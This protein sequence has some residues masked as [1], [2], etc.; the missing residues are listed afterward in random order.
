MTTTTTLPLTQTVPRFVGGGRIERW[1][2]PLPT[3]GDGELLLAVRA[4]ALCG[5]DRA[6]LSAGSAVTPGHEAAGE[7]VSAGPGTATAPGTAG[8]VYLMDYCG[9]CRSCTAGATNRCSAKRADMGFTH[10]GGLGR[11][12]LV[13]E[14]NFFPVGADLSAHEATLL[15]DVMGTTAHALQRARAIQPR[16]ESVAIGGAGPVGLGMVAMTRLLLGLDVPVFIADVVP[17][18]LALADRLGARAVQLPDDSLTGAL[19]DARL[20]G[21][22]DVAMDTSGRGAGRR[23]LLDAVDHGGVL[24]CVGHGEGL[25]L[26]VSADLIAPERAVLGS[27]YFRYDGLASNL[28]LLRANGSYLGQIITHRFGI[29]ELEEAYRV[30]LGGESGKVVVTQ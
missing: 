4:N 18:R 27:E 1:D 9:A 16:I 30:F 19:A 25:E 21:G 29:D 17:Y 10:D 24:V 26:Q 22:V 12:E 13:H 14:T 8:V 2:R 7:V 15:L 11:Y 28:E 3:P 20:P 5:T 23:M 6:Q